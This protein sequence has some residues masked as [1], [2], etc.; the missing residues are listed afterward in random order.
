MT[1]TPVV[2]P[3]LSG[4]QAQAWDTLMSVAGSLGEGWTLIGGQMVLLHQSERQPAAVHPSPDASLRWSYDLDVVVNLR[5]GRSRMD[6]I[7][8]ALRVHGFEQQHLPIGHRYIASNG[9]VF[10]VLAP[11][12]LGKHLPRLGRGNTL[13]AAGGTQ[14]L[15]RSELVE[16]EHNQRRALIPRPSLV[17]AILIKI[18]AASGPAGGRGNRRHLLDVVTLATLITPQDVAAAA[19]TRNERKR[20]HRA[21]Q[22]VLG[23]GDERSQAATAGLSLLAPAL[24]QGRS[25][26]ARPPTGGTRPARAL[27]EAVLCGEPLGPGRSCRRR[28]TTK[29]CPAH[30]DS[31]GSNTIKRQRR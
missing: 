23:L 11:D 9:I 31:S 30:P 21:A 17:G 12:H 7:D 4:Q 14:A 8:S 24:S 15:K 5:A 18:A 1:S 29:P 19:L 25:G 13:Q 22:A 6:H 10:D 3:V 20:I 27:A 28:L 16:V 2:L 26:K